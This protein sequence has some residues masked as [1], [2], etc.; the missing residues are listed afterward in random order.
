MLNIP[1]T[2]KNENPVMSS[3][4]LA[5]ICVGEAKDAHSD[6]LKKAKKVLGDG[7]GNF[8]DTYF[9]KQGKE[10]QCL[11]LPEREA[12][13]MAMS[14]SYE[15]QAHVFDEWQRLKSL[16]PQ[17]LKLSQDDQLLQLAQGV[18]RLT[19]ERDEAIRTKALIND[20][21]TAT[22]MNKASQDAK[23]IKRLESRLNEKLEYIS[24]TASGL[25]EKTSV[26]GK[27]KQTW[28]ILKALSDEYGYEIKK[29]PC[30]RFNQVSAYHVDVID[31]YNQTKW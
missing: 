12:C 22:L 17:P 9:S 14:Y 15:L 6:F 11:L 24:F 8:S 2:Y 4:D 25:P 19:Q 29:I 31:I 13:L 23:K 21:R 10:L 18:I 5:K 20:K 7:V 28:R 16:A 26:K 1:V 3:V 27:V 30:Q